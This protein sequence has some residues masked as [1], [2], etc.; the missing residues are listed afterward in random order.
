[1]H[2]RHIKINW[3]NRT[4]TVFV[5]CSPGTPRSAVK[6]MAVARLAAAERGMR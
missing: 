1:M 2:G 4:Q 3:K 6:K 5:F